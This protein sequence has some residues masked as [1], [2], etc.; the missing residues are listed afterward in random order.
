MKKT[1][2]INLQGKEYAQVKDRIK[3]FREENKNGSISTDTLVNPDGSVI[4]K[5]TVIS[6]LSD[7]NSKRSTGQAFGKLIKEKA[8]EKLETIAV[9]RALAFLGYMADG[10]IASSDEMEDFEN[11]RSEKRHEAID[12]LQACKS[13]EE[14]KKTFLSL[15]NLMADKDVIKVKDEMKTKLS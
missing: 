14:L 12:L 8:F 9:G 11:Y 2:T 4:L 6:D 15:G 1:A 13:S 10:A 3:M 5:A 7:E